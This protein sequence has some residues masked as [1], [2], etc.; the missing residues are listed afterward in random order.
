MENCDEPRAQTSAK[1]NANAQTA[2]TPTSAENNG[3]WFRSS[4]RDRSHQSFYVQV[5]AIAPF[6]GKGLAQTHGEHCDRHHTARS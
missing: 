5:L 6:S 2:M 4:I 3:R 1:R